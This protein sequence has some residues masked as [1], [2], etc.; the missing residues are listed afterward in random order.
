MTLDLQNEINNPANPQYS[1]DYVRHQV[2]LTLS[3]TLFDVDDPGFGVAPLR[4][5]LNTAKNDWQGFYLGA[6]VGHGAT[7]TGTFGI[8]GTSG[9]DAAEFSDK[10]SSKGLFAGFGTPG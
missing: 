2:M 4:E 10:I 9:T 6:Q 5:T 7:Q 8:R 3:T 1:E